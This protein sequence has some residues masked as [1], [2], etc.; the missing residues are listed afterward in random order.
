MHSNNPAGAFKRAA[1]IRPDNA[2][3]RRKQERVDFEMIHE[4]HSAI[5]NLPPKAQHHEFP[6]NGGYFLPKWD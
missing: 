6:V 1:D 2:D 4:D 3:P 5:A